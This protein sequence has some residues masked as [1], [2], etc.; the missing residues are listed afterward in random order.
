MISVVVPVYNEAE[1]V[2]KLVDEI[3]EAFKG[4]PYEMI[5]VNDCST[6]ATLTV[7]QESKEKHAALRVVSHRANAGQSRSVR[8]GI[9]AARRL[10]LGR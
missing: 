8:T 6:D 7:L 10:L 4:Q 5:F 2:A 9:L 1:N 3:A